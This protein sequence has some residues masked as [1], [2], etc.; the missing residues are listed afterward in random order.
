MAGNRPT[1]AVV[2]LAGWVLAIGLGFVLPAPRTGDGASDPNEFTALLQRVQL[3]E[4]ENRDLAERLALRADFESG[5]SGGFYAIPARLHPVPDLSPRRRSA[6][7]DCGLADGVEPG[8]GVVS[9]HGLVGRVVEAGDRHARVM[10]ADD[11]EFR[12]AWV[13]RGREGRGIAAGGPTP[14]AL[15]A[16]FQADGND[17]EAGDVLHTAGG[18][19]VFPPGYLVGT[20]EAAT[21]HGDRRRVAAIQDFLHAGLVLVLSPAP[22]AER[23]ATR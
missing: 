23:E 5:T 3:L 11:P 4:E 8:M 12:V 6:L 1:T 22:V 16:L 15:H 7:L 18:D 17:L 21:L 2:I 20:A 19:G 10:L 13:V 14:G 9:L